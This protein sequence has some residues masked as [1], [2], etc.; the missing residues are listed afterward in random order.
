MLIS[1]GL[2]EQSLLN[3]RMGGGCLKNETSLLVY[4]VIKGG[5]LH[6]QLF[7]DSYAHRDEVKHPTKLNAFEF[8]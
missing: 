3:H 2:L 5:N 8:Q 6:L 4:K 1:Q 7:P